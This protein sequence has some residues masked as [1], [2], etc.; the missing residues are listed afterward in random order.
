M[1][2]T[3]EID[4][5]I[6]LQQQKPSLHNS[7][8]TFGRNLISKKITWQFLVVDFILLNIAYFSMHYYKRGTLQLVPHPYFNLLL[9]FYALWLIVSLATGKFNLLNYP[10][11]KNGFLIIGRCA[12]FKLYS[13]S[14]IVVI[15]GYYSFSRIQ[16]FGTCLLLFILEIIVFYTFYL[17]V[18]KGI[19]QRQEEYRSQI[20]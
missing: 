19:A 6:D 5:A 10:N 4:N 15:M 9:L 8:Q 14:V 20:A 12:V 17:T 11:L 7:L 2:S 18:G 16:I 1:K 13:I 3:S